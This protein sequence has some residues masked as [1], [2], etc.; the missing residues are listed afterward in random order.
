MM[1]ATNINLTIRANVYETT[2]KPIYK[3]KRGRD[4]IFLLNYGR[5][6]NEK[7]ESIW[8]WLKPLP[9]KLYAELATNNHFGERT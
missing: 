4:T 8:M 9:Q 7:E 5:D 3:P 2:P 1:V 6:K